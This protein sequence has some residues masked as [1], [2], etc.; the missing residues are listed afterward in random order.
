[1]IGGGYGRST[2]MLI[3]LRLHTTL[4]LVTPSVNYVILQI[5]LI[6]PPGVGKVEIICL[7]IILDELNFDTDM[8][9]IVTLAFVRPNFS[10]FFC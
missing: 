7:R 9:K 6:H 3:Y 2:C 1:M 8:C 5:L 10:S 4:N